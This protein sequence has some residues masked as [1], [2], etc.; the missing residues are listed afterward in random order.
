MPLSTDTNVSS[1]KRVSN[2]QLTR[3]THCTPFFM[4]RSTAAK[5]CVAAC[6]WA[7]MRSGVMIS[8]SSPALPMWKC[9]GIPASC[10]T[11]HIGSQWRSPRY[12]SP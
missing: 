7:A 5:V 9:T 2:P 12:G 10:V 4:N 3:S 11:A 8:G 6:P 1:G